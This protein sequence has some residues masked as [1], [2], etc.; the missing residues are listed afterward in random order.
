M[1][2]LVKKRALEAVPEDA[3]AIPPNSAIAVILFVCPRSVRKHR[4]LEK[5]TELQLSFI[6]LVDDDGSYRRNVVL[7]AAEGLIVLASLLI[8]FS[9]SLSLKICTL[10]CK[11]TFTHANLSTFHTILNICWLCL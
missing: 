4:N 2:F 11:I 6:I 8:S 1:M 3:M 7:L 9:L 10:I 5:T